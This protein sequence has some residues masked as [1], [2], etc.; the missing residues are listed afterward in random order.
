MLTSSGTRLFRGR[1]R[2]EGLIQV[3]L[4]DLVFKEFFRMD[5]SP[6]QFWSVPSFELLRELQTTPQGLSS[7]E[8]RQRRLR[9]GSTAIQTVANSN[10]MDSSDPS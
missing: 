2:G 7:D 5:P 4:P 3:L 9:Y 8:A 6:T 10:E 1:R